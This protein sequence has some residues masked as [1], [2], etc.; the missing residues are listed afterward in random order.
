MTASIRSLEEFLAHALAIEREAAARY[1]EFADQMLIHN[2]RAVAELFEGLAQM[3]SE[4]H[5]RLQERAREH[6]PA[7][8]R[9]WGY[10]WIDPESPE[11]APL[12]AVHYLLSPHHALRLALANERRACTF[13]ESVAES[14]H[15]GE[16]VRHM[17]WEFAAE[18]K[19]HAARLERMLERTPPPVPEWSMGPD[20]P[21]TVD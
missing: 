17:A 19:D 14:F 6:I 18:E 10:S 3:E 7:P 2:N 21:V 11:A 13:F 5:A 16:D 1:R 12:D 8:V 4:H 9:P 20:P 15:C